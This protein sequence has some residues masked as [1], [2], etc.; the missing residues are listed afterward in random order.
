MRPTGDRPGSHPPVRVDPDAVEP[1]RH[2]LF[3]DVDVIRERTETENGPRFVQI[4]FADSL[5]ARVKTDAEGF[6]ALPRPL[7]DSTS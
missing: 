6:A 5:S 1:S 7:S 4:S 2:K 3:A